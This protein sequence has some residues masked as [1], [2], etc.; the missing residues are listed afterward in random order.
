MKEDDI[1]VASYLIEGLTEEDLVD[2]RGH[3]NR[4]GS[5]F[6]EEDGDASV[7]TVEVVNAESFPFLALSVKEK[8]WESFVAGH[9]AIEFSM[10][11]SQ[12][13]ILGVLH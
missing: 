1:I 7:F 8:A 6:I 4:Y 13:N 10:I 12:P 2:L 11:N 9:N 5:M 3:L